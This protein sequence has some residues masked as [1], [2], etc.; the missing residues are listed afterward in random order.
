MTDK[1][2][3]KSENSQVGK[4]KKHKR[5]MWDSVLVVIG[6]SL[7]FIVIIMKI[8]GYWP[9]DIAA[10]FHVKGVSCKKPPMENMLT[11]AN[12]I[13][14]YLSST[15]SLDRPEFLALHFLLLSPHSIV[16]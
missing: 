2:H 15:V 10:T 8:T 9:C 1:N 11:I 14:E 7:G 3:E 4:S 16:L 6:M 12:S 13:R 5:R